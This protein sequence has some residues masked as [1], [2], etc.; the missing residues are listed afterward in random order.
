MA[1]RGDLRKAINAAMTLDALFGILH[2]ELHHSGFDTIRRDDDWK[3]VLARQ[4]ADYRLLR[5]LA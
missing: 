4:S 3:E 2:A 5:D 1:A